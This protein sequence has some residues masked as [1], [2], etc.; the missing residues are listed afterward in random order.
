MLLFSR[1]IIIDMY[2]AMFLGL[3]LLCFVLAESEPGRRRRW[4]LAMYVAVGPGHHDQ[5]PGRG[6]RARAGVPRL[7]PGDAAGCERLAA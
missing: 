6:R 2:T 3:M 1:R 4:L 5:G 7:P